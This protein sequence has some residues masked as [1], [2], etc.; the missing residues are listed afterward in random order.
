ME[1]GRVNRQA[2]QPFDAVCGNQRENDLIATG[3]FPIL[4]DEVVE[5]EP[6]RSGLSSLAARGVP[7]GPAGGSPLVSWAIGWGT[8]MEPY[9]APME[10]LKPPG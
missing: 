8:M 4:S 2:R 10:A 9:G 3:V 1:L 5:D 7:R 6:G